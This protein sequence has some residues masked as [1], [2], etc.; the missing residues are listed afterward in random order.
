MQLPA[1]TPP[2]AAALRG[3]CGGAVHL[4]GD[5]VYDAARM[6]WDVHADS[7]PLAVAYPAFPDEVAE[8]LRAAYAAGIQVAPQG[9]GHGAAALGGRLAGAVLLRTSAMTELSIDP[10]TR[11][12]RVGAGV[13]WADLVDRAAGH[14]LAALHMSGPD[15]GV[16]GSSLGGGISW[17]ARRYGLQCSALTA[18]EVVLA[19]GTFVRATD[20]ESPDLLWAARGGGGGVGVVTAAEFELLPLRTAYAGMLAWDWT[21]AERVLPVWAEWATGAP[22][23]VTTSFRLFRVPDL[24]E[25]PDGVRGRN[26]ALLDGAVV[27]NADA[28]AELLAPLRALQPDLDTF[29]DRAVRELPR[30]H[31]DPE[32][33]TP[34][35]IESRVLDGLPCTAVDALLA[36]VGPDS[37]SSLAFAELRQLG[38]ALARPAARPGALDGLPGAFLALA[39]GVDPDPGALPRI[40]ADAA[41]MLDAVAPWDAG[42][43]Y[44]PMRHE[45]AGQSAWGIESYARLQAVRA[46]AD[47]TGMF[48]PTHVPM[49]RR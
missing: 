27:G 10:Q 35:Y 20:D 40:R 5:P 43:Q 33:P 11:T 34:A 21:A 6:P 39:L 18:V 16:V 49:Q 19:D 41:R 37:G 14:G 45:G 29:Q 22:D 24:P 1:P 36:A 7:Y 15:V 47:P 48:V 9:T 2:A 25:M 4:P 44:L 31:L 23:E 30:L 28:A 32:G 8:V 46:A 12:A 38:G 26:V 42:R 17:Y 13:Q 3:L